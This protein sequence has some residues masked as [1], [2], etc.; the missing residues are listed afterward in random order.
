[1]TITTPFPVLI[2][3]N[4]ELLALVTSTA[5]GPA[6]D[7]AKAEVAR[8]VVHDEDLNDRITDAFH[9]GRLA[10]QMGRQ[11]PAC[12]YTA[13]GW[14]DRAASEGVTY[15]MPARPEGYYHAAPGTFRS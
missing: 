5:P 7:V 8:R 13:E 11:R 15:L 9:N 6:Q 10:H 2:L 4:T 12:P 3:S 14:D 1:M